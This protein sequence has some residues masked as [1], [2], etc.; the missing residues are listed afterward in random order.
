MLDL[1][2]IATCKFYQLLSYIY[3]GVTYTFLVDVLEIVVQSYSTLHPLI[4]LIY[5]H[6]HMCSVSYDDGDVDTCWGAD[7]LH[8][9]LLHKFVR[10]VHH[11]RA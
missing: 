8:E 11:P 3:L 4:S 9:R 1:F 5:C 10:F 6:P 7:C 2:V